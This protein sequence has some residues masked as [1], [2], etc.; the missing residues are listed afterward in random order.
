MI[1]RLLFIF[2]L[3]LFGVSLHAQVN[4]SC[5]VPIELEQAYD[6]DVKSLAMKRMNALNSPDYNKIEIPQSW[7]DTI[8][9]AIAA[10][11]NA[12]ELPQR[13]SVFN[14]Y[15]VHDVAISPISTGF[16]VGVDTES[17]I[18][19]AWDAGNTLTGNN[20]LDSM[21]T[22]YNF[23]LTNYI[24]SIGA[25]VL[26]TDQLLNLYALGNDL[27][28]NVPAVQ[29]GEPDFLIGGAGRITFD[30]D[31]M[32]N[33]L[34]DFRFEWNDCFDGCD[35]Y[36]TWKFQVTPDCQVEY[37][38]FEEFGFFG[39]EE[40]PDPVNCMLTDIADPIEERVTVFPNPFKESIQIK[41]VAPNQAWRLFDAQGQL[42]RTG[43]VH[44]G[45]ISTTDLPKGLY[46]LQL[47][48]QTYRLIRQ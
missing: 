44:D 9:E 28:A 2:L 15:C 36:Y 12:T 32:G 34:L 13:D 43:Q 21:L 46:L 10:V 23:T 47:R 37:L 39:V 5:N 25:G 1:N 41:N 30:I 33:R 18:G 24:S 7:Q 35:N 3:F 22:E 19:A 6:R 17:A 14:L 26:Q 11:Y 48:Q 20:Y 27:A 42:L 40:L 16:L 29:Y 38:G 45:Q 8:F 4:S 31:N